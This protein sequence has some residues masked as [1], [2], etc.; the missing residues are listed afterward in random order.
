VKRNE[1]SSGQPRL[2]VLD[3]SYTIETIRKLG[4]EQSVL[5]RDL[6]GFFGHVW[7][8]H[9]FGDINNRPALAGEPRSTELG[10]RH[11]FIQAQPGRFP[12]LGRWF[13]L[14]FLLGQLSLF[15]RLRRLVKDERITLIR[16]GDPLYVG[17]FGLLL[18]RAT[19]VPLAIRINANNDKIRET[20]GKPIYPRLLRS[21]RVEKAI[22]RFVLPRAD[23]VA[24][25]NQDNVD[26]AVANGARPNRVTIF[27]YGNLLSPAH[28]A[29]PATRGTDPAV[30]GRIGVEPGRYL[31]CVSRLQTLKY[32]DDVVRVLAAV[33]ARGHDLSLV[34][35]GEGD[36]RRELEALAR[37][38]AVAA[39][40]KFAGN[41]DQH[42]LSQL[43]ANAAVVISPLTGRALSEAALGAA[44]IVAYDLDWQGDLIET[45][46]TGELVPFR[47]V[48]A[49]SDAA[50]RLIEDPARAR[51][52]GRA[53]RARALDMLDPVKLNAHERATYAKLLAP[54]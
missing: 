7:S 31:L 46:V 15:R 5:C 32:P 2:L 11:S 26:F 49:L 22:E 17:L 42:A 34:L 3:G 43:Y 23:L 21:A 9:P 10:E 27:R 29:E 40:V 50:L 12:A 1:G 39:N 4:L 6:D 35:A 54:A 24:A 16:A 33:R 14:N 28:L 30:F 20:T 36:L 51:K 37:D 8:V 18:A 45:G 41:L 47:S 52:L 48:E 19:G 13:T 25:P 38:L 44:P 53:V